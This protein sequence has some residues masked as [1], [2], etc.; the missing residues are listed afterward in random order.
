MRILLIIVS[1]NLFCFAFSQNSEWC[2]VIVATCK[3]NGDKSF[4]FKKGIYASMKINDSVYI[5]PQIEKISWDSIVI[6]KR[7][8]YNDSHIEWVSTSFPIKAI[9]WINWDGIRR[10]RVRTSFYTF[11]VEERYGAD[12]DRVSD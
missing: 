1:L 11:K 2:K 6:K 4:S 5:I 7:I 3:L 10:K 8:Y 12:C 9:K